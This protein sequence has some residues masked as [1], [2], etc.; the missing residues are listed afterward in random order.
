MGS[1]EVGHSGGEVS[2]LFVLTSNLNVITMPKDK[3]K[4]VKTWEMKI[5]DKDCEATQQG[6]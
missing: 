3:K 5:D 6:W 4:F 2:P 1:S